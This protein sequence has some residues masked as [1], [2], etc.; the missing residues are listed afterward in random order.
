MMY[1]D[2]EG[3]QTVLAVSVVNIFLVAGSHCPTKT[4]GDR[5]TFPSHT[6][7]VQLDIESRWC[8]EFPGLDTLIFPGVERQ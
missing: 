7:T 3:N 5:Q 4:N 6:S 8:T 1:A 2:I